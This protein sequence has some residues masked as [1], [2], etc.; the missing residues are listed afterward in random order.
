MGQ[1]SAENTA[2][3]SQLDGYFDLML[4]CTIDLNSIFLYAVAK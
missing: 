3:I 2:K 4:H 1:N